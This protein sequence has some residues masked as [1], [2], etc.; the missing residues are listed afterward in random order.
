M[1]WGVSSKDTI[2]FSHFSHVTLEK[3]LFDKV[4]A[5]RVSKG[6]PKLIFNEKIHAA[7]KDH[8]EYVVRT[9]EFSHYQKDPSSRTVLDR[10]LKQINN[11]K[12]A[13]GE[14]LAKTAVLI[15][16]TTYNAKGDQIAGTA[17]TYEQ[18]AEFLFNLWL[19]SETHR[20]NMLNEKYSIGGIAVEY[21]SEESTVTAVQVFAH[22]Y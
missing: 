22:Y 7:A 5:F 21:D 11:K 13:V 6:K 2:D 15:P 16:T 4:N 12:C 19:N 9:K 17:Y 14:N 20:K 10:V 3:T 1:S 18:A 8:V